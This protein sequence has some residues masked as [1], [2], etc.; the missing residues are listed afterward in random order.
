MPSP[1]FQ[2]GYPFSF[3]S[4]A[5][6]GSTAV[7]AVPFPYLAQAHVKVYVDNTL[8]LS[9]YSWA[10]DGSIEFATPPPVSSDPEVPNNVVIRRET[11]VNPVVTFVNAASLK[12]S[13]LNV[14]SKQALYVA[15]EIADVT[16]GEAI[17][18]QDLLDARDQAAAAAAAA[19]SARDAAIDAQEL[20]EAARDDSQAARDAAQA[21]VDAL[22]TTYD[23]VFSVPYLPA[24]GEVVGIYT[25]NRDLEIPAGALG[26]TMGCSETGSQELDLEFYKNDAVT[27]FG[28]GVIPEASLLGAITVGSA[29]ELSTGDTVTVKVTSANPSA[30]P[31]GF[32][33]TLKAT[34]VNL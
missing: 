14:D 6:N 7:F 34:L 17:L 25:S 4:Y 2:S 33:I 5:G 21:I 28:T 19:A 18:N 22:S 13:N 15:Q 10:T 26:S 20:S 30:V 8:Q 24:A 29:V 32:G 9:G 16:I 3:R 11:P 23:I 12:A 31:S 27:P 1:A